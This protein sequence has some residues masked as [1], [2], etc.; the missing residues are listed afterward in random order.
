MELTFKQTGKLQDT[1]KEL[2]D[3]SKVLDIEISNTD[4]F[5]AKS[6]MLETKFKTLIAIVNIEKQIND[7]YIK[8]KI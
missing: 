4:D 8:Q 5:T 7:I 2:L 1:K 3:L 6:N